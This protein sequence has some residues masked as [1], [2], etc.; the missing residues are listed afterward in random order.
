MLRWTVAGLLATLVIIGGFVTGRTVG[1]KQPEALAFD[2]DAVSYQA[3]PMVAAQ[4]AAGFTGLEAG[5]GVDGAVLVKGTVVSA[6]AGS[7]QLDTA[8][9]RQAIRITG[10]RSL[11]QF[12]AASL[13]A[14]VPGARVVV[15]PGKTSGDAGAILVIGTDQP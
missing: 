1:E 15:L 13:S 5:S 8:S 10:N 11:H 4:T 6:A 3:S 7:I 12:Q 2:L 9:G 14:L